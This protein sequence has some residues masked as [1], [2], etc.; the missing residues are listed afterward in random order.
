MV[1]WFREIS[2]IQH[3]LAI[4]NTYVSATATVQ[5]WARFI[6]QELNEH[7]Y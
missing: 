7:R 4:H 6:K 3:F 2:L 5:Y 1:F